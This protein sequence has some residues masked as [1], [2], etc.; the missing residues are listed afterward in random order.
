MNL[1]AGATITSAWNANRSASS[2]AVQLTNVGWNGALA[3]GQATEVGFQATG[4]GSGITA[5]CTAG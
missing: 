3:A 1:P 4:S 5:T 2:G